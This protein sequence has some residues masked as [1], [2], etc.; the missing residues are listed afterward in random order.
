MVRLGPKYLIRDDRSVGSC[1]TRAAVHMSTPRRRERTKTGER[2]PQTCFASDMT[3]LL[4]APRLA[5]FPCR[6]GAEDGAARRVHGGTRKASAARRHTHTPRAA[7]TDRCMPLRVGST[8]QSC[9]FSGHGQSCAFSGEPTA[10]P[11]IPTRPLA[12]A[13]K[14]CARRRGTPRGVSSALGCKYHG[15][16]RSVGERDGGRD[17]DAPFPRGGAASEQRERREKWAARAQGSCCADAAGKRSRRRWRQCRAGCL[18]RGGGWQGDAVLGY[19]PCV[20]ASPRVFDAMLR[21]SACGTVRPSSMVVHA[22]IAVFVCL[23]YACAHMLWEHQYLQTKARTAALLTFSA[24]GAAVPCPDST[25]TRMR[26]LAHTHT[27]I[28]MRARTHIHTRSLALARSFSQCPCK[29]KRC[30]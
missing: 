18:P 16:S 19:L 6:T 26:A 27:R 28:N 21:F 12:G 2:C 8:N 20:C 11:S 30:V 17:D 25:H 23:V 22:R 7:S 29:Q 3:M 5:T 10:T 24:M 14:T 9:A 15:C 13:Q 4:R 1:G